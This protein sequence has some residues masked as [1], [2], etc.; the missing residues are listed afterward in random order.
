MKHGIL[1]MYRKEFKKHR[2]PE[3]KD[4]TKGQLKREYEL[5]LAGK[6]NLSARQRFAVVRHFNRERDKTNETGRSI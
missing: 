2:I 3:I 5:I 4:L 1:S 6:S